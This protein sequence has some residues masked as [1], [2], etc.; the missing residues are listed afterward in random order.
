M[1]AGPTSLRVT[2]LYLLYY[3]IGFE[4]PGQ[5]IIKAIQMKGLGTVSLIWSRQYFVLKTDITFGLHLVGARSAR[6]VVAG[7][8]G[9]GGTYYMNGAR[10]IEGAV[11]ASS[12]TARGPRRTSIQGAI[13]QLWSKMS[14]FSFD[15]KYAWIS[16]YTA[17]IFI[18]YLHGSFVSFVDILFPMCSWCVNSPLTTLCCVVLPRYYHIGGIFIGIGHV[19][20]LHTAE[21]GPWL[22]APPSARVSYL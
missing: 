4:A 19:Q 13:L 9:T 11:A 2:I 21:L 8:I 20:L 1:I 22:G 18:V 17:L 12:S 7:H 15:E 10:Y 5:W 14:S 3:C 6:W 16:K